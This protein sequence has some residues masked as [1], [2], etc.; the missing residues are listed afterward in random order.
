MGLESNDGISK[1]QKIL[2]YMGYRTPNALAKL[3]NQ[4]NRDRFEVEVAKNAQFQTEFRNLNMCH[5]DYLVLQ[6]IAQAASQLT[7]FEVEIQNKIFERCSK[8]EF[9]ILQSYK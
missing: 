6:E 5:G 1:I 3:L 4:K 8:V 2:D 9:K 7:S